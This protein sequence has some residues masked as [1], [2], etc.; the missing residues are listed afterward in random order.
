MK[1]RGEVIVHFRTKFINSDKVANI[2]SLGKDMGEHVVL[3]GRGGHGKSVMTEE[4]FKFHDIK[5]F[6]KSLGKGTMIDDLLGGLKIKEFQEEGKLEFNVENSFMNYEYVVFEE[7]F[8]APLPVLEQLKDILTAKEFRNGNQTFKIKTK[9]IVVCTNRTRHEL[10]EDDSIKALMERFPYELKVEWDDYSAEEY[11]KMF[12]KVLNTSLNEFAMMVEEANKVHFI[13]PR[14]AI[15]AAKV[16]QEF[17]LKELQYVAGFSSGVVEALEEKSE[18]LKKLAKLK[19]RM[20]KIKEAVYKIIMSCEEKAN[21]KPIKCLQAHL[22]LKRARRELDNIA[23]PD[24]LVREHRKLTN[25]L[26]RFSKDYL[27]KAINA[28]TK[29]SE[30]AAIDLIT[31]LREN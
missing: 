15:K 7:A 19:A 27:D 3:F 9:F 24:N 22:H 17:G 12:R 14:T 11:N 21:G 26:D 2:L 29:S 28:T 10:A 16:Y 13:S 18:E 25:D 5:P 4:F 20:R 31:N 23:V 8:D 1:S 6:V 30:F